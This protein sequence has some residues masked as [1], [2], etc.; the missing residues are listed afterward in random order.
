MENRY[1]SQTKELIISQNRHTHI[2]NL[3]K[4]EEQSNINRLHDRLEEAYKT[5]EQQKNEIMVILNKMVYRHIIC[6]D[7]S[8]LE[9][10][11]KN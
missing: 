5:I 4:K 1:K 2:L 7:F 9:F 6:L 3:P 11:S 10:E 8:V